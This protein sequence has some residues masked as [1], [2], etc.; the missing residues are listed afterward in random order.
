MECSSE[1]L[2]RVNE[3]VIIQA[4][5][6]TYMGIEGNQV[7]VA[8]NT[9]WQELSQRLL[10][11]GITD[12]YE[13]NNPDN[14][15]EYIKVS[16]LETWETS[17]GTP[18]KIQVCYEPPA[19]EYSFNSIG[20]LTGIAKYNDNEYARPSGVWIRIDYEDCPKWDIDCHYKCF[21]TFS[22]EGKSWQQVIDITMRNVL[23][24]SE[25]IL[26]KESFYNSNQEYVDNWRLRNPNVIVLQGYPTGSDCTDLVLYELPSVVVSPCAGVVCDN[27]CVG[28][29]L[30]SQRCIEGECVADRLLESNSEICGYIPPEEEIPEEEEEEQPI[31]GYAIVGGTLAGL[32]L[33]LSKLR[34]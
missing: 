20:Y 8:V 27:V 5:E 25:A 1:W 17:S 4:T 13:W 14:P 11:I 24:R 9:P 34:K 19:R 26:L 16:C 31:V 2:T 21:G 18:I 33:L 7:R 10:D 29:D 22:I 12:V 30:Y 6:V 28:T 32:Y 23:N 15:D 3:T